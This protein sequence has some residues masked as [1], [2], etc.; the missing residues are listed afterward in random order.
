MDEVV[1]EAAAMTE[2]KTAAASS[3][4][5]QQLAARPCSQLAGQP[6]FQ[7]TMP[8]QPVSQPPTRVAPEAAILEAPDGRQYVKQGQVARYLRRKASGG[9]DDWALA[10]TGLGPVVHSATSGHLAKVGTVLAAPG[11][12]IPW[13]SAADSDKA[14]AELQA[15]VDHLEEELRAK[16]KAYND[17]K[18]MNEQLKMAI[19]ELQADHGQD[20]GP[21]CED[22]SPGREE[23]F[24]HVGGPSPLSPREELRDDE[25]HQVRQCV[26]D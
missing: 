2:T 6:M 5:Q 23:K 13:P 14:I 21:A 24:S 15:R 17:L 12:S 25:A 10:S 26:D 19:V 9:A 7:G 1:K 22:G 20:K 3:G 4:Q 11:V 18:L 16:T 8:L